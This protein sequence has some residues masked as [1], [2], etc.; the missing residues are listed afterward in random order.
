MKILHY[1]PSIDESS[2]GVGA[3]MQ[4]ISSEL[5][6]LVELHVV[7]HKGKNE[8]QLE[9]C[10]IHYLP[11]KWLPWNSCKKEFLQ[12]LNSIKPDVF[13][14]NSCWL[15][16]SA[17]TAIWAKQ[18]GYKV[19]YTPHGM[20]VSWSMQYHA[21]KKIPAKWLFQRK[22]IAICDAIHA[23]A[24]S[25]KQDLLTLGWNKN[26]QVI[27]NC[28]RLEEVEMKQSWSRKNKILFFGR[29]HEVKGINYL[30]EAASYL[31]DN[32]D[33]YTIVIAGPGDVSYIN[34]LKMLAQ[35]LG[36]LNMIEFV[37]PVYGNDKWKVYRNADLMVL[38]SH[39]ENFG[40]V[41]PEALASGT[42][43][44]TTKG[45]PWEELN[46][47]KCGWW[48]DVGTQPLVNA[49]REFLSCTEADLMAMGISGRK[50]VE[51]RYTSQSV[52]QQFVDMYRNLVLNE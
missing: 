3:Y 52:S 18:E 10:S 5:G 32:L 9:N 42:P 48:V 38:P 25:E 44:I 17:M 12:L 2:G 50:L 8:R 4:L 23:T 15:P 13:H 51:K 22:G 37:G 19:V 41:V 14:T 45:T 47:Y 7:T 35:G 16:L 39:T 29:V 40:I 28:I 24:E 1:I 49:L 6:K 31:K 20:L 27:P 30:I 26:I 33:G 36:V 43:V 11:Y 46:Q 21:W 34:E